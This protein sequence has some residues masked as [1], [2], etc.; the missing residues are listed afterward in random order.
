MRRSFTSRTAR[1]MPRAFGLAIAVATALTVSGSATIAAASPTPY[2]SARAAA[3]GALE[4]AAG[5]QAFGLDPEATGTCPAPNGDAYSKAVLADDPIAYYRLDETQGEPMCDSSS[6]DNIG[7]YAGGVSYGVPGALADDSDAAVGAAGGT[8]GIGTSDANSG[9]TGRPSF[10]LE[11]WFR[12]TNVV[13]N[14]VL[15]A[16]GNASSGSDKGELVGLATWSNV[17]CGASNANSF[18]S[19]LGLDEN[20]ASNCWDTAAAGVNLYDG[21]WHFLAIVH[22]VSGD[23]MTAYVDGQSLGSQTTTA[24]LDL[25]AGPV[26]VGNWINQDLDK[27]FYG[28][29]DEVAVFPTALSASEITA[30]YQA[31]Q[32]PAQIGFATTSAEANA[33]GAVGGTAS[34]P[35]AITRS[36]SANNAVTLAVSGLPAGVTLSGGQTIAAGSDSTTLVFSV[37]ASAATVT[38]V[39]ITISAT[40]AGASSPTPLDGTLTVSAQSAGSITISPLCC[41]L[42]GFP[43]DTGVG[44]VV[45]ITRSGDATGPVSL[46]VT[47]LPATVTL[48]GGATIAAGSNSTE[49]TFDIA[50]TAPIGQYTLTVSAT[51]P[52]VAAP[53]PA[54]GAFY[55]FSPVS[56]ALSTPNGYVQSDT[57]AMA[58]CSAQTLQVANTS[59]I[60][61]SVTT[62]A[63]GDV[64]GLKYALSPAVTGTESYGWRLKLTRTSAS[65]SG[66]AQIQIIATGGRWTSTATVTVDLI[67]G[68]G[69][70]G[71]YVTQGT[72]YDYGRLEPSGPSESGDD[73]KGVTL[74]AG[75]KTVVVLYGEGAASPG[76]SAELYG[77][78]GSDA[79]PGSPIRP[80]YGPSGTP[81]ASAGANGG[82]VSDTELESNGNAFTFTLPY[83]WVG[84]RYTFGSSPPKGG[85]IHLVGKLIP[86]LGASCGATSSFALNKVGFTEV[87]AHHHTLVEPVAMTVNGKQPPPP[88]QVFKEAAAAFPLPDGAL[89]TNTLPYI[90][91][92]SITDI[93]DSKAFPCN[94]PPSSTV[95]I[96]GKKQ[97]AHS[98]CLANENGD[99][100]TRLQNSFPNATSAAHIVG[101][102]LG[103]AYG[104][105]NSVPGNFSVVNGQGYRPL[106]SVAHEL[107]HQF[108]LEHASASCGGG[109][110]GQ[111]SVSW[112]PDQAGHINGIALNTSSEPYD[113]IA[114][115][116]NGLKNAYD[117]MSYCA[118]QGYNSNGTIVPD[119]NDW[120]S[121]RNWQQ[122]ISNF[123]TGASAADIASAAEA[124]KDTRDPPALLASAAA[125]DQSRLEVIGIMTSAGLQITSVGPQVGGAP[126]AADPDDSV[127]LTA[128]GSDGRT[129]ASV[130]MTATVGGHIDGGLGTPPIPL[131]VLT[132]DV[133]AR[134]VTS[135]QVVNGSLSATVKR[136]KRGPQVRL[137]APRHGARVGGR[138]PVL[139]RW[140]ATNRER[141]R[142]TA[143]VD[144]SSDAG[145]TWR[146]VFAGPNVGH[147][148]LPSVYFAPS[149]DARVRV[150]V[151]DGFTD[152]VA[153][154]KSFVSLG[155]PPYVTIAT[156]FAKG[157][158][159]DGDASLPLAGEALEPTGKPI[160][161][162]S[163]EWF[164]G[165][166]RIGTGPVIS[167]GP[168]PP[169]TN[170][171]RLVAH[172][173]GGLTS[174]AM[175]TVDIRAVSLP[176]LHLAFPKRVNRH[177]RSLSFH[178]AASIPTSLAIGAQRFHLVSKRR[179][180]TLR[181]APGSAP[182]LLHLIATADG[183]AN[184]F[185]AVLRRS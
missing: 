65:A 108:G 20:G 17:A 9:I 30:Q 159:Y 162:R 144:Y 88:A 120:L 145:R 157:L 167:S 93:A 122:L 151:N 134:G 42:G 127:T 174:S 53:T 71:L 137:L 94:K 23:T 70:Q 99:V 55:V 91:S 35:I 133:P 102:T 31:A 105:T 184:P 140:S 111:S 60:S 130:P 57:V 79:L 33:S 34:L 81:D 5:P 11:G 149:R 178:A 119:P 113:F 169:G 26:R 24:A 135:I 126:A 76:E 164:D 80:D 147:V 69:A 165:P 29:A 118:W 128:R 154:S 59:R 12:S 82:V 85:A 25:Q 136:P 166:F 160:P 68:G 158:R 49:L 52:G 103:T 14:Q 41:A 2:G 179:R 38:D 62:S 46:T 18:A 125:V 36:S 27:Y 129:L 153:L 3:A 161:A 183:V 28:D 138:R 185:A 21:N 77:Y 96:N 152:S 6:S 114:A 143:Y 44:V 148:S 92:I 74:V 175:V 4:A 50:E 66:T 58:P 150:L 78:R 47:G 95:T 22:D 171:I 132:G 37:S 32:P 15:V 124:G 146:T 75:K 90:A 170:R 139:I 72:Q 7:T 73:Y 110:N 48:V 98:V 107:G 8:G 67:P 87:G 86:Q 40:S 54:T 43:G 117:F 142:L 176:F 51:S 116:L 172:G 61:V 106:T 16:I 84:G 39:P 121:P 141:L 131:V 156:S 155:A 181:I 104:L 101:V 100:L 64:S 112:P 45:D 109:A 83:S 168:L 89:G 1:G 10:T 97:N 56:V 177:A 19:T 180:Y 182:L 115:G 123:G 163:L 173:A 13:Q 63:T